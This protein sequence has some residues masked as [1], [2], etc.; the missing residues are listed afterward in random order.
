MPFAIG[1]KLDRWRAIVLAAGRGTRMKSTMPKVL[2]PICGREMVGLVA[3]ALRGAG[4]SEVVAVVP[5]G[6]PGIGSAL[7]PQAA[8]V[9]Q[10][11]PRGT[12]HALLQVRALLEGYQGN[13]LVINGDVPLVTPRT[14]SAMREHHESTQAYLTL[15]T[16]KGVPPD[17]LGRVIR[18]EKGNV[19]A[20]VEEADLEGQEVGAPEINVG[21][22]CLRAPWLWSALEELSP[23]SKGEIYLTDL[24]ALAV[25]RSCKVSSVALEDPEA[26]PVGGE[27]PEGFLRPVQELLDEAVGARAGG[28]ADAG[29]PVVEV[30][31][32]AD[33]MDRDAVPEV[34]DGVG[35]LVD[36]AGGVGRGESAVAQFLEEG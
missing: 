31:V 14:L 33:E 7:G 11:E 3:D 29:L 21:V 36:H 6:S 1:A 13:V 34:G 12:G 5:P 23:S 16:C 28:A 30:D 24:V 17:G 8:L 35:L 2:Q 15:L 26:A 10:A 4:L 9:E 25:A 18:G 32:P 27:A 20:I 19:L 22:Y